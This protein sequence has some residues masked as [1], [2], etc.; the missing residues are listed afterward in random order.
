MKLKID[1]HCHTSDDLVETVVSN[2]KKLPTPFRLIDMAVEQNFH[3]IAITHH[4]ILYQNPKVNQYAREKGLLLIPGF[5]AFIEGKHVLMINYPQV[6]PFKT[7]QDLCKHRRKDGL[8]IAPHPFYV[9]G[10]CVGNNLLKYIDCFDAVEYSRFHYKFINPSKKAV[11]IARLH[12]LPVVGNSDAHEDYQFGNTY[13]IVEADELSVPA[14]IDAIKQG[15]VE[16]VSQN[17]S[18]INFI[19]DFWWT[20]KTIPLETWNLLKRI[21]DGWF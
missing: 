2:R 17:D 9:L 15:K 14:I 18:L 16:Y 8:I 3:A 20:V 12:N 21:W 1:L 11:R 13:S 5:E 19:K 4:G 10:K 7:Y 6:K